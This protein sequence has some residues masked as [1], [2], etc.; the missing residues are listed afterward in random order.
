MFL[1]FQHISI[2]S[3]YLIFIVCLNSRLE[4]P[5]ISTRAPKHQIEPSPVRT[6]VKVISLGDKDLSEILLRTDHHTIE[7][8]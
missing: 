4:K 6:A 8:P 3:R 2:K 7:C 1:L 5:T